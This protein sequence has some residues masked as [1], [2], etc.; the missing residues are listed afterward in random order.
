MIPG[1]STI[2]PR[3][4]AH[5]DAQAADWWNPRGSS[6]M[7]HRLNPVRLGYVRARLDAAWGLDPESRRPLAGRRAL[8]VGCGA[9]LLTEPL[10]RLG[11]DVTGIDA[12]GEAIAAARAHADAQGLAIDYRAGGIEDVD[13]IFDLVTA[14]EVVEHVT[15][16]PAFAAGL[17]RV[18]APGGILILS[19]PNRTTWSRTAIVTLAEGF[20]AIPKGTHDWDRFITPGEMHGL[21]EDAGLQVADTTGLAW[22]PTRGFALSD[23]RRLNYLVTA[24]KR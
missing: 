5:F 19:T 10:A 18:L 6:A 7:L 3:E 9:G 8:D 15:D 23:D 16:P 4:A 13:G 22:S 11:A 2:D 21:L 14:L 1:T 17:A 24:R 12:A 20:G